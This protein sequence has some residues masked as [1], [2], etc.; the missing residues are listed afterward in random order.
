MVRNFTRIIIKNNIRIYLSDLTDIVNQI[1]INHKY[2]PF[3]SLIL[4]N[5]IVALAPLKFL[6]E[7]DK[8][9]V[10]IKSNGAIKSLIF[11]T[12]FSNVRTLISN[13]N[14]ETEYDNSSNVNTIPLI[15][16]IGDDGT[17]EVSREINGEF[18]NSKTQ[19]AKFDIVTDVAYYLNKSD[20]IYSAVLN[21]VELDLENKN[22]T[23]KSKNIIFQL[24]P[25][26]TEK[27]KEWIEQFIKEHKFN[28]YSILEIEKQIDGKLL[29]I[30]QLYGD[31]WCSKEKMIN[32]VKLLEKNEINELFKNENK[33]EISCE[34]CS[35]KHLIFKNDLFK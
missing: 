9:L 28:E 6:Y 12:N 17:L 10:R 23:T 2:K 19:L 20:Q 15:L 29:E 5:A 14:I 35:I 16:G 4:A 27:D 7:S 1:L 34:F 3:P 22:T 8:M 21:D 32:A 13:P 30:K 26:H 18:F 31:C 11:E 25:N 33:I 24:L